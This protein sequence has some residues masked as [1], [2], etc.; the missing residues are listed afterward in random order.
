MS[1]PATQMRPGMIIKHNNEL[2]LVF[3]VEHRTP[4]NL[5]AFIQ[6]KLRNVRTGAMF[7]E[8]FRSPDPIERVIV[9]EVKM[10]YLYNDGEDYYFMDDKYEQ[11]MLKYETLGDAVEYLIP[12]LNI[13]VSFHDGKAV[14]IELP[15]VVE[16][17]VL[18]TEPGIKSATASSVTKPAKTE[19]GLVVQVPPFIN[20]GEKIRVDTADGSYM[21]RA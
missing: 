20:E 14:G 5:R 19:T 4:G 11:T 15:L 6:A 17:T 13:N 1:I 12:N 21:S 8:R 16:M 9:D 10:E 2:H 3:S 18:E 7:I